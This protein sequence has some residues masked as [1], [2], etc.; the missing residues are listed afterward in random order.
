MKENNLHKATKAI[1]I[2]RCDQHYVYLADPKL[3]AQLRTA[4][5]KEKLE[6]MIAS[7]DSLEPL[8]RLIEEF[9]AKRGLSYLDVVPL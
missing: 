4:N 9:K 5:G 7:E 3:L 8:R 6:H 1:F 2:D